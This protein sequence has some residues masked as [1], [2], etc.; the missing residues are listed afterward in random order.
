MTKIAQLNR[1]SVV[2]IEG[3]VLFWFIVNVSNI[4]RAIIARNMR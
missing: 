3:H 1:R 4:T 2:M